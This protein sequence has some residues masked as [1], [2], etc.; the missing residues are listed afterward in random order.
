MIRRDTVRA[1][2]INALLSNTEGD[3]MFSNIHFQAI[4]GNNLSK[5][6]KLKNDLSQGSV[7]VPMFF[8]LY[9]SDLTETN[10][11]KV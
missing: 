3:D 1:G 2:R 6:R 5:Q 4:H 10:A 8:N 9:I 11:I 7:L